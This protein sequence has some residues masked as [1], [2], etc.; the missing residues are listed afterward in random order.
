[1]FKVPVAPLRDL[2]LK[3]DEATALKLAGAY[4]ITAAG[5]ETTELNVLLPRQLP[6]SSEPLFNSNFN[7]FTLYYPAAIHG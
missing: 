4:S 3:A 5:Y 2:V 7:K 1:M 6:G